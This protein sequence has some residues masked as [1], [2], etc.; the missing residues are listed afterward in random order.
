VC[1]AGFIAEKFMESVVGFISVN[2]LIRCMRG[3]FE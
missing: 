2:A 3:V 1:N